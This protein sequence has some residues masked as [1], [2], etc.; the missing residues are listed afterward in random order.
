[1]EMTETRLYQSEAFLGV[2]IAS[3]DEHVQSLLRKLA[4]V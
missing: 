4:E 1:M 2:I 3:K